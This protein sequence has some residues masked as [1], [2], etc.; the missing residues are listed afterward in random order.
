MKYFVTTSEGY[1]KAENENEA[2][3]ILNQTENAFEAVEVE[4]EDDIYSLERNILKFK[5]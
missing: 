2:I 4:H 3:E 5:E 1:I